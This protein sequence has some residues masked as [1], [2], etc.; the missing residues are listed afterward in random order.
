MKKYNDK[1]LLY[2]SLG[3]CQHCQAGLAYPLDHDDAL[4]LAAWLCSAVLKGDVEP[5]GHDALP[6]V[7]WK[8][9][10]ETSISNTP[11]RTTRPIGTLAMT[12]GHAK[13][14][15]CGHEWESE[16][17]SACGRS[18]HWFPGACPQCGNDCGGN[19]TWSS[20]DKRTRIETRYPIVVIEQ[21]AE[22]AKEPSP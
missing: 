7:F 12:V 19:G 22:S 20:A 15:A 21:A 6:F 1:E 8:V 2:A 17:Y 3:R 18:H 5:E 9:R 4:E 10:E 16:P 14:G 11:G 13:C